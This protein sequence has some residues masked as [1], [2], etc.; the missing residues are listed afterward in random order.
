[1]IPIKNIQLP[2]PPVIAL[3][4]LQ[5]VKE[6]TNSFDE[7]AEII[8]S[9]PALTARVLKTA[10]STLYG[11]KGKIGSISQATALIGTNALR[12]IAL[13]FVIVQNFQNS[14]QGNFDMDYF[15]RRSITAGVCAEIIC[16]ELGAINDEIFIS[17]LLQDIGIVILFL[18]NPLQYTSLK[19]QKR[20]SRGCLCEAEK[21][22][23]GIDHADLGSQLLK[24]WNL[25]ES[26]VF[27]I[28]NHHS[29]K[30]NRQEDKWAEIIGFS[31]IISAILAGF[32]NVQK[33]QQVQN[34]LTESFGW[35][36][37]KTRATLDH[38]GNKAKEVLELFDI[39]PGTTMPISQIIQQANEELGK[40]NLS[41]EHVILELQ[42]AKKSAEQF[43]TE[44]QQAN[45]NL[46][47]LA[48][49]D[50]LTGL[51]NHRYFQEILQTELIKSSESGQPL[52]LMLIDIDFFKAVNDKYGHINGDKVLKEVGQ[53][54]VNLVRKCDV[55]ARY[56]GEEFTI[57]LP[58]TNISRARVL[59]QRVRRG[60]EQRSIILGEQ[61]MSVTV[62]IGLICSEN[63]E[64]TS[65]RNSQFV[66]LG[67]QA[68]YRAKL[69]GRNRVED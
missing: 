40:L 14:P 12:N 36:P 53:E 38:A 4:I 5:A 42:Q 29:F 45:E 68:L 27:S 19:D 67:D 6:N 20:I 37:E 41:Y 21:E 69:L 13:S 18:S 10:N 7:L 57:I 61:K 2:S 59:A 22:V 8:T 48:F 26:I 62:S 16:K 44:L 34:W 51:Y 49:R 3:K 55:V 32:G 58:E 23:F 30:Q 63:T 17:A 56:G 52:S 25:P 11:M 1:M 46:R 39:N 33:L 31:G 24:S 15:W 64:E 65:I 47:K 9:D 50:G 54:L 66:E 28:A 43:A 35:S 60:I